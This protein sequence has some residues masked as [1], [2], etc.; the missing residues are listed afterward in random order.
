MW[1]LDETSQYFK[2][3]SVRI[4]HAFTWGDKDRE[5]RETIRRAVAP[6][7]PSV[8]PNARW[9]AFRLYV[10]KRIEFDVENVP[11]LIVDAFCADQI[12]RDGSQ[13]IETAL[14][15]C[16]T[17]GFVG[18]VQVAGEF[19]TVEDSTVIEVFGRRP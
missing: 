15:E 14:Y 16:D 8:R 1:N 9:W 19:G 4:P 17:A 6:S 11:K 12:R 18:M 13:Y 10:R 7:I 2:L 3:L 5:K